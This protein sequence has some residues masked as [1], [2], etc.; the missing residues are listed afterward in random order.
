[1]THLSYTTVELVHDTAFHD[2]DSCANCGE[3]FQHGDIVIMDEGD[4]LQFCYCGETCAET[5]RAGEPR[6]SGSYVKVG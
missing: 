1:M 4:S 3:D 5:H 6:R 2:P